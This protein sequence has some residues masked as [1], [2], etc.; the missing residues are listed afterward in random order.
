MP[1]SRRAIAAAPKLE[2]AVGGTVKGSAGTSVG[3][4]DAY[5]AD[6]VTI[7]LTG[8]KLIAIPPHEHRRSGRWRR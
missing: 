8:G 5:R 6:S 1:R 4:L 2:L 7:K 3:T